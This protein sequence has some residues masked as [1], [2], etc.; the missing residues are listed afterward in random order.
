M[1][2][3]TPTR[4]VDTDHDPEAWA[5]A[6]MA[7]IMAKVQLVQVDLSPESTPIDLD[8]RPVADSDTPKAQDSEVAR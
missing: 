5:A 4:D 7:E 2:T 3:E 1:N 8:A 6:Q